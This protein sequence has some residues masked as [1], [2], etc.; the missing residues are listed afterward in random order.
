MADIEEIRAAILRVAR[1]IDRCDLELIRSAYHPD[2]HE[3]HGPY[4]GPAWEYAERVVQ[5]KRADTEYMSHF[6]SNIL[7]ELRG[8]DTAW[9]ESYFL[10]VQ[11][12]TGKQEQRAGGRYVDRFERRAGEWKIAERLVIVDWVSDEEGAPA[13]PHGRLDR[14]DPSYR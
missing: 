14:S 5:S 12:A 7:V 1:G 6:V 8:N 10:S 4:S 3:E 11:R 9:A 13:C 2:A